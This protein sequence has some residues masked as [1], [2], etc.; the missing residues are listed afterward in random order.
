M[1]C[2]DFFVDPCLSTTCPY[3]GQCVRSADRKSVE[4]KCNIACTFIYDPVCGTDG[5]TYANECVMRS[6]AC[7]QKKNI[8]VD[9][10]GECEEGKCRIFMRY[11][12]L[13]LKNALYLSI[14]V[15][16][17]KVLIEDTILRLLL[18]TGPLFYV[19]IRA[20]RS[21]IQTIIFSIQLKQ[22]HVLAFQ[23]DTK[24]VT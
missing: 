6:T 7:V 22:R 19:F 11:N 15:F 18:E 12:T 14:I 1:I 23:N 17:K 5:K 9:Y 10:K 2:F 4:C 21:S 16:S 24:S 20:T 13:D 8:A 3:Y